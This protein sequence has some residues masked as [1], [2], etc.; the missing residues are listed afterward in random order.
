MGLVSLALTVAS[1]TVVQLTRQAR[2][3]SLLVLAWVI[4]ASLVLSL[5]VHS[6]FQPHGRATPLMLVDGLTLYVAG[7]MSVCR[8]DRPGWLY[9]LCGALALQCTAHAAYVSYLISNNAY[10]LTL[11]VLFISELGT[12]LIGLQM[13]GRRGQD[14]S[15]RAWLA[16]L[17]RRSSLLIRTA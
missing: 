3:R 4:F 15:L 11:N 13:S 16:A 12:L 8:F 2:D 9:A 10:I 5:V 6:A 17:Q 14:L 7:L 1:L